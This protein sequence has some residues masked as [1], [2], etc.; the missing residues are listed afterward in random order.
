[1]VLVLQGHDFH[2]ETENICRLFLPQEKILTVREVP[3]DVDGVLA[4]AA[5]EQ[6]PDG[7]HI[8]CTLKLDDFFGEE[9]ATVAAGTPDFTA[10]CELE[11]A[12]ALYRSFVRLFGIEQSWGV[13]TGVRPVKLLRSKIAAWGVEAATRW[14][15]DVML[16]NPAK[17][18]LSLRTWEAEDKLLQQT[19]P[20]S[21]S[22][23][24]SIPFC[25]TRCDYC[26]FVSHTTE[27]SVKL[28]P[29]YLELLCEELKVTAEVAKTLG[30]RLE[31][32]YFGGGTPT[33]L[34]APQLQTLLSAVERHFDLSTVRE[35]TVEAGRPDT[36]TADKLRV[37]R[38]AGV[39]RVS[40]NPQTLSDSV[41]QTIGRKHTAAQFFDAYELAR[42]AGFP[43]INT[44]LI[45]GLPT[46]TAEGF[47]RTLD[48]ILALQPE[49]VTVHTLSMKRASNLVVRHLSDYS[50]GEQ[51][52][53]MTAYAD[54]MLT[55]DGYHPYYLYRQARMVGNQENVG[56][57]KDGHDGLYNVWIMD[58]S[59]TILAC[60]AGAATKL[61]DPYSPHVERIFNHKFPYEY[62][63][64]FAELIE[65]KQGILDFYARYPISKEAS[66]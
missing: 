48:G 51:A 10:A 40:I 28:I 57:S 43:H 32:V 47:T 22:L 35:Y 25:P 4:V 27:R 39:D 24:V 65:R 38:E 18:A 60:G 13:V 20:S 64:R 45:V 3:D 2:F 46:D 6:R 9:T 36:V 16:V 5:V 14:L 30:L 59:Q 34:T 33:S 1:M 17:V 23:Y 29:T 63:D 12:K 11:T 41:L 52:A 62:N 42:K 31:S 21:F 66:R 44:D 19:T 49:N 58:E 55:A 26:S 15:T 37:I 7:A 50:G 8:R 54:R 53:A 61:K 56:W